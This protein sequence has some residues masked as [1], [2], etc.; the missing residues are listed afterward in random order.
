MDKVQTKFSVTNCRED[1]LPLTVWVEPLAVAEQDWAVYL[2]G[3]TEFVVLQNGNALKYGHNR[4][5]RPELNRDENPQ[6]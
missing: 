2:E 4:S 5:A 3:Q 6:K 1:G